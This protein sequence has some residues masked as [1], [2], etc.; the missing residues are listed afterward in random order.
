MTLDKLLKHFFKLYG[1]RDRIYL[2]SLEKRINYLSAGI[3]DLQ[4]AIRKEVQT[5]SIGDALSRVIRRIFCL[6]EYFKG[7]DFI[8]TMAKKYPLTKCAYCQQLPCRCPPLRTK[9][10]LEKNPDVR[11]KEWSFKKWCARFN[12]V[13]G[14]KNK[15]RGVENLLIRLFKKAQKLSVLLF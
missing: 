10:V 2:P 7:L 3:G 12:S 13:Y 4:D 9:I 14:E 8:D 11:Q 1:R 15:F 5:L 6:M